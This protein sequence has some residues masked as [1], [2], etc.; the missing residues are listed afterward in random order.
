MNKLRELEIKRK[1]E[2]GSEEEEGILEDMLDMK[3]KVDKHMLNRH[4]FFVMLEE[5]QMKELNSDD[6][7]DALRCYQEQEEDFSQPISTLDEDTP[8]EGGTAEECM[9]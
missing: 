3:E 2:Q 7:E 6:Y 9:N 1:M 4:Q 8:M 5:A